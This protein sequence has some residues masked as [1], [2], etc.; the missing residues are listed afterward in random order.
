VAVFTTFS[1]ATLDFIS[2]SCCYA[3]HF[4]QTQYVVP[5]PCMNLTQSRDISSPR[6]RGPEKKC[7]S[8]C[9]QRAAGLAS[10]SGSASIRDSSG[11]VLFV[12]AAS[13]AK[14]KSEVP[15]MQKKFQRQEERTILCR[16][17]C[18]IQLM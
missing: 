6:F 1:L 10:G 16:P 15:K 4:E 2:A 7:L 12:S 18:H 17:F 13:A 8:S 3:V 14:I 9:M 11:S 5:L